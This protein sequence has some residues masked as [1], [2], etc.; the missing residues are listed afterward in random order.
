[1][2]DPSMMPAERI[3]RLEEALPLFRSPELGQPFWSFLLLVVPSL[4]P[5][6][7]MFNPKRQNTNEPIASKQREPFKADPVHTF[8]DEE[9]RTRAYQIYESG[10]RNG[11]NP[12][13]DWS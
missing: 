13:A 11:N 9:I 12:E 4:H 2:R 8:S 7:T 1:M 5:G 3:I 10:D 6:V